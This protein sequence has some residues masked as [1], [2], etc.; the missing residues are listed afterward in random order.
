MTH[1]NPETELIAKQMHKA[2]GFCKSCKYAS[3]DLKECNK[4]MVEF[5]DRFRE[6]CVEFE[7]DR[8]WCG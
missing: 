6:H 8:G 5:K 1:Q 4:K 7:Y 3:E 2:L